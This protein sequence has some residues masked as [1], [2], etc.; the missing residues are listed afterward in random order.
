MMPEMM[1]LMQG[2]TGLMAS[3]VLSALIALFFR[4]QPKHATAAPSA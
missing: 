4:A 3:T 2:L 1:A